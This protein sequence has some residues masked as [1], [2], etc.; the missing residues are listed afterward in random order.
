M[1]TVPEDEVLV[2]VGVDTHKDVHVAVALDQLGRM[3]GGLEIATTTAGYAQ[4]LA[5]AS[6]FGTVDAIGIEGTGSHGAGLARWLAARG[7]V[8]VEVDRPDRRTR[9][10][11]GKSDTIDAESAARRVLSGEADVVPKSQDGRVEMIRLLRLTRRSAVIARGQVANQ[12]H[13]IITT[14]PDELRDELRGLTTRKRVERAARFRPG[15]RL[16]SVVAVTKHALKKLARRFLELDAE[17]KEH[18]RHLERLVTAAAPKLVARRGIGIH[19]AATLLVT[20]GD[21]PGRLR[22]EASFAALTGTSPL[23]ASSGPR[24]RHRLNRGGDRDANSALHMI[25]VNRLANGHEPTRAYVRKRTGTDKADLDTI[26]RLK[27]FIVREV[28]P[29]LIEALDPRHDAVQDAA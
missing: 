18:D 27:R 29:L 23:E 7:I 21:N 15:E 12:M 13:A 10:R 6:S 11:K 26:R 8:V 17:I 19:T 5:W 2:T 16:N 1:D 24:Q 3:L 25:A 14:A 9:R 22:S 28:Y 4:L 20:A